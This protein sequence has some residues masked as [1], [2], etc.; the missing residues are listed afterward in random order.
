VDRKERRKRLRGFLAGLL[1]RPLLLAAWSYVLWGTLLAVL[2]VV[3]AVE[4]GWAEAVRAALGGQGFL[5]W[6]NAAALVL[7]ILAWATVAALVLRSR[8]RPEEDVPEDPA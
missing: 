3:K 8:G 1:V 4:A 5:A 6:A 7:A 2:V